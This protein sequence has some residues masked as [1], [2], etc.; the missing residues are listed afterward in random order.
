[1]LIVGRRW[2][3]RRARESGD[4]WQDR[5][6]SDR[7]DPEPRSQT[8]KVTNQAHDKGGHRSQAEIQSHVSV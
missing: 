2:T 3:V 4:H 1:M 6:G 8:E 7:R 5:Q